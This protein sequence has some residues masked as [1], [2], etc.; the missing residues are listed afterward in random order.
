MYTGFFGLTSQPFSIAPNPD[1]L[2]LSPRHAEALAHLRY[3]LGEA[4]GFVLLTGEVGTGKTTVSRCL[5]QELTDQTEVAFILNPTLNELELLA[6]ICDQLKIRYKKSDASLKML[7]DKITNRLMK[8][9]QAGKNTILIIDEAQHLQPA[10]L[11]Q[12]RL[13]TNLETNTK[14]LLQVILIGQPELQQLLQRQDLR[15]LAQRITARY[16]LMPLTEQEVQQYI[17]YRLQVAGCSRPV[18]TASAVKKLFQLSGGIPRLLNLICD[19]ALLGGY[20][21][22]KALI[23]AGLVN[24]AASE[25]L[26]IK[27]QP[28]K[29][30]WPVW[31]WPVLTLVALGVGAGLSAF[32]W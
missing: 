4:G 11:E 32:I 26:A 13:L 24:Q 12:L 21:Q 14:K 3:G 17:S 7:T 25:V 1:F 28:E 18:F 10:V 19:R 8:N 31:L 22:Q 6:A 20:S 23:D 30:A 15:Q 27:P 9:H 16:H 29:A 5:L 2:F